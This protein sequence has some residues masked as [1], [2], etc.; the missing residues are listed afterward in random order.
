MQVTIQDLEI[1][2]FANMAIQVQNSEA[3]AIMHA[4]IHADEGLEN[5]Q[6]VVVDSSKRVF[7]G[8]SSIKCG[9]HSISAVATSEPFLEPFI[10][11]TLTSSR[12]CSLKF[13]HDLLHW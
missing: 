4:N 8:K 13:P 7:I 3:V 2:D 5:P 1:R 10:K 12:V 11:V 9:G 6:G